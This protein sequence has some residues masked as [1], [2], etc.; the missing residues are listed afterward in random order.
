MEKINVR[1][2]V[3]RRILIE[4]EKN[5]ASRFESTIYRGKMKEC[6]VIRIPIG[7]PIYRMK[8]GRTQVEQILYLKAHKI[9]ESSY[10]EDGEENSSVQHIQH[11]FLLKLSKDQKGSIYNELAHVASQRETLLITIDGVIVNGNRRLAAMRALYFS[12]PKFY[13]QFSHIDVVVLPQE[14]VEEDLD[15]IETELQ[16]KPETK[17]EYGWIERRLKLRHQVDNINISRDDIKKV[18]RFKRDEE[19]NTEIQQL[20]LAEEYLS[21]YIQEPFS[22]NKITKSEQLFKDLEKALGDKSQEEKEAR[23]AVGFLLAKESQGL[24]DR[25]YDFRQIFGNKFEDVMTKYAKE[26]NIDL[27]N[28]VA[29]E[30]VE[31]GGDE[32]DT[33][34]IDDIFGDDV[35]SPPPYKYTPLKKIFHDHSQTKVIAGELIRTLESVKQQQK[36]E[37]LRQIGLKNSMEALRL[38]NDIDLTKSAQ[39]NNSQ[40]QGQLES[41][42]SITKGLLD[43]M[44]ILNDRKR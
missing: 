24:G 28:V 21:D 2:R 14:A 13:S 32:T 42:I 25:V 20:L 38:L 5:Q 8:N 33:E 29:E 31:Y 9:E 11:G 18:Y 43:Q 4:N 1:D 39:E 3:E 35:F 34:E 15:M 17:L 41:I 12:D 6:P 16:L 36:E 22:Y 37:S 19:I 10:F 44:T 26:K 7:V 27:T 30:A 40:I 23:K